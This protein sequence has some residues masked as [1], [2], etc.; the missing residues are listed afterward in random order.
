[1]A[2]SIGISEKK[3][4]IF[5]LNMYNMFVLILLCT[6]SDNPT[7]R[8]ISLLL[9]SLI[10]HPR[11]QFRSTFS[12]FCQLQKALR[13]LVG[14]S[15]VFFF[16]WH[17]R[18]SAYFLIFTIKLNFF[19]GRGNASLSHWSFL[20]SNTLKTCHLYS[21]SVHSMLAPKKKKKKKAHSKIACMLKLSNGCLFICSKQS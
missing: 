16:C 17:R 11:P 18:N 20:P 1:M 15:A 4:Q 8:V 5:T 21:V 3:I 10:R 13:H 2:N 19:W 14:V 9:F 6:L 7:S 12:H